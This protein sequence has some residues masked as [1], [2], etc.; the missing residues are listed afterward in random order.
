MRVGN[1]YEIQRQS[2]LQEE[3][4]S[5]T[6][7]FLKKGGVVELI[8]QGVSGDER[9]QGSVG[10]LKSSAD[11]SNEAASARKG[12]RLSASKKKREATWRKSNPH[13]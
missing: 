13:A 5:K 6:A 9:H 4:E 10:N 2:V 11:R 7:D 8:P 12:A 1:I 3:I